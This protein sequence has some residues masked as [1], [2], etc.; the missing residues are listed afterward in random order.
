MANIC[1]NFTI[2]SRKFLRRTVGDHGILNVGKPMF[3][4]CL[5][6]LLS[7]NVSSVSMEAGT[8]VEGTGTAGAGGAGAGA[9]GAGAG[10]GG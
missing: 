2:N 4:D 10:K 1:F 7:I 9:G 8:V 6:K 3:L 5:N